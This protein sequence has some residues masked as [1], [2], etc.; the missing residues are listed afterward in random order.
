M[1]NICNVLPD[2]PDLR[3]R[4][5]N[6]T[7]RL[8]WPS[9]NASPFNDVIWKARVKD[10][11]GS[12]ACIGFALSSM[13]EILVWN[14]W[15]KS[16]RRGE[17]PERISPLM[18]YY[19]ARRYD[20]IPGEDPLE[21]STARGGMKAWFSQGACHEKLWTGDFLN[22]KPP[23]TKWIVDA[24]QTPLGAYYRVDHHS[25]PD[26]QAA[27]NET[28]VVY[29]TAQIHDGWS[30]PDAKGSISL[31]ATD[32]T[33]GGHAFLLVGY[34][35]NGFWILNSWGDQWGLSG[36][37]NL[38]YADWEA[39]GMDAWVGQLGV[40]RSVDH[41]EKL[42]SGLDFSSLRGAD[43]DPRAAQSILLSSNDSIR[44]QQIN[45]Y[46]IN[47]GNNGKL[48]DTG[49]Y[50]TRKEDLEALFKIYLPEAARQFGLGD[51]Q[52]IDVAIYAH[53]GLTDEDGA[54]KTA[55]AW[56]AGFFAK[57]VFPIFI[58]WE[59]GFW[60]TLVDFFKDVAAKTPQS[61]AGAGI[62][63]RFTDLWDARLEGLAS[64]PGTLEWDEMK[65]NA[66]A[67]S[68][69]STSGLYLLY[70]ELRKPEYAALKP[71]L[72]L[73]LIGHSAGAIFH[74]YLL[75]KLLA[76]GLRVDGIY[77]MA[78]AC[79][80]ELFEQLILPHYSAGTVRAFTQFYLTDT[81]ERQDNCATIYRRSLLYLVSNAFEHQRGMPLLGMQKFLDAEKLI[82]DRPAKAVEWRWIAGPTGQNVPNSDRTNSTSHGGFSSDIDTQISIQTR[83]A[84]RIHL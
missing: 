51:E 31:N 23:G 19:Y 76:G 48:S 10:Q 83:I 67:A 38:R 36:F 42:A 66:V 71:R 49:P 73:H 1:S 50:A 21:G 81:A 79:R 30:R 84:A 4:L 12:E 14:E 55:E 69:N 52:P 34:D 7:L 9:W 43:L 68:N 78:P 17:P 56:V 16:G 60:E 44:A 40:R 2:V 28:G 53:G 6:P 8:L 29:V 15:D 57:K 37:A 45:P 5:Y 41:V 39:N 24:F 80:I 25:V 61:G 75:E 11:G 54:A 22:D 64:A 74:G 63:D 32:T 59:T 72:R 58:M 46:I 27:I 65:K 13:V 18:L 3:D 47:L 77:F 33:K 62:L 82:G 35:E 26:M 70:D 20:D